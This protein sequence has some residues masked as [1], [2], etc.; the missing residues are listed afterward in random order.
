MKLLSFFFFYSLISTVLVA[1]EC[2]QKSP[3]APESASDKLISLS[4]SLS[5]VVFKD[6]TYTS[7]RYLIQVASNQQV[8]DENQVITQ[9]ELQETL[10]YI[11]A[12][13][14]TYDDLLNMR[15]LIP[16]NSEFKKLNEVQQRDVKKVMEDIIEVETRMNISRT[17]SDLRCRF[18]LTDNPLDE[19][20]P[21]VEDKTSTPIQ[22]RMVRALCWKNKK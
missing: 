16:E 5:S 10:R 7:I 15:K 18:V 8:I 19:A 13:K 17:L 14:L 21:E 11:Y 6:K 9:K 12:D 3:Y 20:P 1:E 4:S 22:N 2:I